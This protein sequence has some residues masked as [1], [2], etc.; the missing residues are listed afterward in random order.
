MHAAQ[1]I[2]PQHVT[3]RTSNLIEAW[4][5]ALESGEFRQCYGQVFGEDGSRCVFGVLYTVMERAGLSYDEQL[6]QLRATA[7]V[8]H[9]T[10]NL[11]GYRGGGVDDANDGG[12]SLPVIGAA[13]R[14]AAQDLGVLDH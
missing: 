11:L 12:V 6:D 5:V 14:Q 10:A 8:A 2:A 3:V 4:I 9:A 1:T 13:M 7:D